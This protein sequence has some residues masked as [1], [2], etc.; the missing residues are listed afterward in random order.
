LRAGLEE[1]RGGRG[2]FFLLTGDPG[3]GKSRLAEEIATEA[4]GSGWTVLVGRCWEG[5]GAPAY[6]PFVQIIRRAL[7]DSPRDDRSARPNTRQFSLPS[8]VAQLVPDLMPSAA[9]MEASG[10]ASPSPEEARFNLFDAV[11]RSL[12]HLSRLKPLLLIFEDLHDADQPTLLMLRLVVR[13]L[14]TA[15]ALIIGTY[16]EIEVR[17]PPELSHLIGELTRDAT[18]LH[19]SA[20]SRADAAHMIEARNGAPAPP[21]LVSEIYQATAGNPLF[22]D[23]LLRVLIAEDR[24]SATTRVNL[25]AFRVPDGVRE[26][27]RQWLALLSNKSTLIIAATIGQEFD[28]TCLQHLTRIPKDQLADL[29]RDVCGVGILIQVSRDTYRFSHAL[30]RNTLSEELSSADSRALH[31]KIGGALEEIYEAD[32][33]S[34]AGELAHHFREGGELEKAT[35]YFISAGEAASAVFAYEE[36]A[37]HWRAALELMPDTAENRVRRVSLLDRFGDLPALDAA[38]GS[39]RIKLLEQ[40]R[41]L[42]QELGQPH[43]GGLIHLRLAF[44]KSV[45]PGANI[46][47]VPQHLEKALE[48]LSKDPVPLSMILSFLGQGVQAVR[49]I[50]FDEALIATQQGAELSARIGDEFFKERAGGTRATAFG[51][52]GSLHASSDLFDKMWSEASRLNDAI[53]T[54]INTVTASHHLLILLDPARAAGWVNRE[55]SKP[56]IAQTSFVKKSLLEQLGLA[57]ALMGNLTQAEGL[58]SESPPRPLFGGYSLK[59]HLSF[60][61]GDWQGAQTLLEQSLNEEVYTHAPLEFCAR[62]LLAARLL[63]LQ[64]RQPEARAIME[65]ALSIRPTG[66]GALLEMAM[67]NELAFACIDDDQPAEAQ[68]HLARC[69]EIL[70]AGEDWRGLMGILA[71][72]EGAL[73]AAERRFAEADKRFAQS[74]AI[75]RRYQLPFEEA[76]TYHCWGR[77]RLAAGDLSTALANLNAA[78]ELYRHHGAGERWL[79][80]V[81]ADTSRVQGS[82]AP[83]A[84]AEASGEVAHAGPEAAIKRNAALTSVF[85]NEGEYWTVGW[86]GSETRL[87]R[88]RGLDYIASLLRHPGEEIAAWELI[89]KVE[90]AGLPSAGSGAPQVRLGGG[91]GKSAA[92]AERARLAVTKTVKAALARIR[93]ADPDLGRHLTSSIRTGNFCA[94]LPKQRVIWRL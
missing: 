68:K 30:I 12:R 82:A 93:Q 54:W 6:W 16:R 69:R 86:A 65:K 76:E 75:C 10:Q 59:E 36:T 45:H 15:P 53:G 84:D 55:M 79:L 60:Y 8:E 94:Y 21:R 14:R 1:A 56:W 13:E 81:E 26:A 20:L 35:N 90:P 38:E 51:Y 50:K 27:I 58:I 11:A 44:W 9:H 91:E 88:R 73:A 28:L 2:R 23:G 42:Y 29:L 4:A 39:E 71:R 62:S 78:A 85:R 80:R 63:R 83:L 52:L 57:H 87:K 46:S 5:G 72:A 24:L 70:D 19:L 92:H 34:H 43:A 74:V 61:A 49:E 22:I 3:I 25:A 17:R 67:R 41:E 64:G 7:R 47:Q 40:A 33:L 89:A 66:P 32:L 37:A 18:Q 48:L 31:L 77:A